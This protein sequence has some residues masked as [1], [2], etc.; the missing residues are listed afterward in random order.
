MEGL[1]MFSRGLKG[2]LGR[3]K[4]NKS[5]MKNKIL[6]WPIWD[7]LYWLFKQA[8]SLH[9]CYSF[10]KTNFNWSS[11]SLENVFGKYDPILAQCSISIP[12]ENVTK[13]KIF[14][15]VQGGIEMKHWTKMG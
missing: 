2:T 7:R 12:P 15:R 13:P 3:N 8:T 1:L 9:V 10:T 5:F 11:L 14:W 6:D 4:L